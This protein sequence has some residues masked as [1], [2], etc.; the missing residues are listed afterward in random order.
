MNKVLCYH[1]IGE[2]EFRAQAPYIKEHDL[3]VTFDD[4]LKGFPVKVVE[5]FG[6]NVIIFINPGLLGQGERMGKDEILDLAKRGVK[7]GNHTWSHRP[8]AHVP[9]PELKSEFERTRDWIRQNIPVNAAPEAVALPKGSEC[10]HTRPALS[11]LGA[12]EIYGAERVDVYPGRSMNYFKL[13][14]NPVFF[15]TRRHKEWLPFIGVVLVKLVLGALL[16]A[17]I[18]NVNLPANHYIPSGGDDVAYLR[19]AQELRAGHFFASAD[20]PGYPAVM[21]LVI[22]NDNTQLEDIATPLINLNVF[23][24]STLAIIFG[25]LIVRE[26][27]KKESYV[28][29]TG[30][31][32][33]LLPYVFYKLFG[34]YSVT[35]ATGIVDAIGYAKSVQLF[36]LQ[37][38][39]DWFSAAIFLLGLWLFARRNYYWSGLILGST[40]LIR[41]QNVITL[42]LLLLALLLLARW[43]D[44]VRWGGAAFVGSLPQ[45]V[46]NY[47]FTGSIFKFAAY[48]AENN[49]STAVNG[50]GL[51]NIWELPARLWHY[52]PS[53]YILFALVALVIAL[54]LWHLR[55]NREV[56][57]FT[58]AVGV[59]S[60]A[61]LFLTAAAI[62]NPRY[63]I[64][65]IPFFIIFFLSAFDS[66]TTRHSNSA[67]RPPS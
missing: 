8:L 65:F 45:L 1:K 28:I 29:F 19:K 12:K 30:A 67:S 22:K 38:L 13:S 42:P 17:N 32:M 7:I 51:Q 49:A 20:L 64:P 11:A 61:A 16:L 35:S 52:L 23:V 57:Y 41:A 54:G 36:G 9:D 48:S 27:W 56:L 25:M 63:F 37:V 55:K 18:P 31:G 3:I 21:A 15:W 39:S 60:P 4:G 66:I 53:A 47:K 62:R 58:I 5:E 10:E 46:H 44:A 6:L 33:I 43:K 34:H 50:M 59:L 26:I 14:Q 2:E 40:I 24:F